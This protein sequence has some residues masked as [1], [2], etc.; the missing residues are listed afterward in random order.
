M[1]IEEYR[2]KKGY[3]EGALKKKLGIKKDAK[4]EPG[5]MIKQANVLKMDAKKKTAFMGMV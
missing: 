4:V 1:K 2:N 3:E 5:D